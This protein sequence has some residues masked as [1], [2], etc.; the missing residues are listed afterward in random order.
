MLREYFAIHR[1]S[2]L[3]LVQKN[4]QYFF[5]AQLSER[6]RKRA[7]S[8]TL[9]HDELLIITILYVVSL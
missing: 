4:T 7:K 2:F 8:N 1:V 6:K 9:S 5:L 3:N